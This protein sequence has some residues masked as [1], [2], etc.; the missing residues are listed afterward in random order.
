MKYNDNRGFLTFVVFFLIVFGLIGLYMGHKWYKHRYYITLYDDTMVR[1]LDVP[2]FGER[3]SPSTDEFR[4]ECI[5]SV[6]TSAEQVKDFYKTFCDRNGYIFKGTD[7]G[8]QIEIRKNYE[9]KGTFKDSKL[10]LEWDPVL[11]DKQ[12]A[13]A[14]SLFRQKDK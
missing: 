8:L 14:E 3:V 12:K 10:V 13:K 5:L 1:Y 4:G 7:Y 2:P 6:G 9:I 11:N